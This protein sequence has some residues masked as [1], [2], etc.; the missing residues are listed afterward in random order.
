VR[1]SDGR[2]AAGILSDSG[3]WSRNRSPNRNFNRRRANYVSRALLCTD[4][5]DSDIA[6]DASADLA[7]PE[8][9]TPLTQNVVCASCHVYLDPLASFLPFREDWTA[10][11]T[12]WPMELYTKHGAYW[13]DLSGQPPGYFGTPGDDLADLGRLIA[14]DPR[15]AACTARRFYSY[16]AQVPLD[17]VDDG[18]VDALGAALVD[19]G[20]SAKALA[21]AV[22]LDPTMAEAEVKRTRPEAM[23]SV[24]EAFTGY[25]WQTW[26][27]EACCGPNGAPL[28]ATDLLRDDLVGYRTLF[29]GIDSY[30][31]LEPTHTTN[32]TSAV[33]LRR[34]GA[35][36]A[37]AVVDHDLGSS[38]PRLLT[39]VDADTSDEA[40][41]RAQLVA[42]HWQLYGERLSASDVDDDWALWS[43]SFRAS[44]AVDHA[45]KTTMTALL[46]DFDLAFY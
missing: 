18:I 8:D 31:K 28:G 29:G 45:W 16:F 13:D 20:W 14:A 44:G 46:T 22:I 2:P 9:T 32:A 27:P 1:W 36:A 35:D 40:G 23:A 25:R 26:N 34:L 7:N 3:L 39:L 6:I 24:I 5:L 12:D 41:I 17:Q 10:A 19:S 11:Q 4:F 33:V 38:E 37:S 43:T 21:R 42:L 30:A 15:F